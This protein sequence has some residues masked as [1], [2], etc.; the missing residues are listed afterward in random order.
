MRTTTGGL[1]HIGYT[2]SGY[3]LDLKA[4]ENYIHQGPLISMT[5][6]KRP[7][8]NQRMGLKLSYIDAFGHESEAPEQGA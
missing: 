8:L 5:L 4:I 6:V 2:L 3:A 1:E 7:I